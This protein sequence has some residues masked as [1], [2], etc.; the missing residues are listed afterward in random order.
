MKM[1]TSQES[2][3][4][5]TK[6]SIDPRSVAQWYAVYTRSRYEK[7]VARQLTEWD[8]E[9]F[10]PLVPK[11]R[12]WKDRKKIIDLP[13]F[14]SYVFVNINLTE[15]LS[16]LQAD[17]VVRFVSFNGKPSPIPGKQIEDVRRLLKYPER[18]ETAPYFAYGD[19]VEITTG[20]FA[21][22]CGKIIQNR[23]HQRLLV[24][25]DIIQQAVSVEIDS[26]WL[27]H[28]ARSHVRKKSAYRSVA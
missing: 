10:L 17:G 12:Y 9:H 24:G 21:G 22:I 5:L 18:V 25:I 7:V 23:G 26:A 11:L 1:P 6:E 28:S 27:R 16:V 8:V 4:N 15:R 19:S 14:P 3:S 13:I 2:F 20:P